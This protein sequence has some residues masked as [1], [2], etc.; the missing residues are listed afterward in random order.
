MTPAERRALMLAARGWTTYASARY[1]GISEK[2][3]KYQLGSLRAKLG[4]RNTTHAVVLA[5]SLEL[6][7]LESLTAPLAEPEFE[8]VSA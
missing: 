3:V 7:T 8:E 1:L 5:L 6:V 4:A 2:T